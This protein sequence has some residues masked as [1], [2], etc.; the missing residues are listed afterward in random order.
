VIQI[1]LPSYLHNHTREV[2]QL[3]ILPYAKYITWWDWIIRIKIAEIST[4]F[5]NT[6]MYHT[7]TCN[8]HIIYIPIDALI[9]TGSNYTNTTP[10]TSTM[11]HLYHPQCHYYLIF[12]WKIYTF[13]IVNYTITNN[14]H[15]HQCICITSCHTCG[16]RI[17]CM[18][19]IYQLHRLHAHTDTHPWQC[20]RPPTYDIDSHTAIYTTIHTQL[21]KLQ[22]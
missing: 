2:L 1:I 22:L 19:T 13:R 20:T 6:H 14:S 4:I 15:H 21:S 5:T 8:T 18:L 17:C 11:L 16:L 7:D 3:F 12:T 9:S 10:T